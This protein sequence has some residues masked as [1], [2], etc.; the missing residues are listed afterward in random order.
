MADE[1]DLLIVELTNVYNVQSGCKFVPHYLHAVELQTEDRRD[2]A[3]LKTH[4]V[5]YEAVEIYQIGYLSLYA[6][7][8]CGYSWTY[9]CP[10]FYKK[11]CDNISYIL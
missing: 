2:N 7:Y 11:L 10:T 9:L 3:A 6:M 1:V 8:E 5:L 4:T